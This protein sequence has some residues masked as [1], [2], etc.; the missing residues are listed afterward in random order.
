MA[1]RAIGAARRIG[2]RI[3]RCGAWIAREAVTEI[4]S[5]TR[6]RD[7][8]RSRALKTRGICDRVRVAYSAALAWRGRRVFGIDAVVS[9]IANTLN[10]VHC[11]VG[12]RLI[13]ACTLFNL[14]IV[15]A[16]V[17]KCTLGS[18]AVP[19]AVAGANYCVRSASSRTPRRVCR[20]CVAD[21]AKEA[22]RNGT[23]DR[24]PDPVVIFSALTRHS[25]NRA[26]LDAEVACRR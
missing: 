13:T 12:S 8:I 14:S 9:G 20:E 18:D 17:A 5:V 23:G 26:A 22:G 6:A 10:R 4:T 25:I 1:Y 2:P 7:S 21:L 16:S 24:N 15:A 19:P 11:G 3:C